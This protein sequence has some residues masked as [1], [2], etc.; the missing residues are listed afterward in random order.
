ML[1]FASAVF[2]LIMTPGPGVLSAAGVSAS[3][4]VKPAGRYLLG[5]WVG[6]N[7]VALMVISGLAALILAEPRVRIVMFA[8]SL[9]VLGYLALRIAFAGSKIAFF[10]HAS[11][12]GARDGIALQIV[13][14]K[15]YAVTTSLFTGFA[16][17]P[18]S[19]IGEVVTKMFI[20]NAIWIPI[21][22][23]WMFFGHWTTTLDLAPRTQRAI[24]IAMAL[25][26]VAVVL[27]AATTQ[28]K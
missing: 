24:N 14:P 1:A 28:F 6:N 18:E 11:L 23:A 19:Y 13:N 12:P 17:W 21:H 25:S 26:M 5:L 20:F 4:G 7:L 2:L 8:L 3:F 15:A 10:R 27:I 9:G 16:Y 22:I